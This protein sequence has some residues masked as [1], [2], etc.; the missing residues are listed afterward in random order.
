MLEKGAK[1][2]EPSTFG[3]PINWAAGYHHI[4]TVEF[5]ISKGAS[6][7][8]DNKGLIPSPLILSA[9]YDNSDL[10]NLLISH[11]ADPNITD[12]AGWSVLHLCAEK[13]HM[14]FTKALIEKG[15]NPNYLNE[16]KTPLQLAFE[17]SQMDLYQYLK[18]FTSHEVDHVLAKEF[19]EKLN[20]EKEQ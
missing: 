17:H 14:E 19:Q 3:F 18:A 13:G 6:P 10:F 8:G 11:G 4:K 16:K 15:A 2:E 7:N 20:L 12:S 5:L 9:D 1:I